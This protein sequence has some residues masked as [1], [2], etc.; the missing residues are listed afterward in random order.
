MSRIGGWRFV[1]KG[2]PFFTIVAGGAFGLCFFQQVR[3]DF[4]R[5][6]RIDANLEV[7][8]NDLSG[9]G[10]PVKKN[11]TIESVLKEVEESDTDNWENVRGPREFEDN[12]EFLQ[13]NVHRVG[14]SGDS[15][16]VPPPPPSAPNT[17]TVA[18]LG[19]DRTPTLASAS[20]TG[21]QLTFS[22]TTGS[23]GTH[24]IADPSINY[25]H[26]VSV[27]SRS[28]A[29]ISESNN[30]QAPVSDPSTSS[31]S[32]TTIFASVSSNFADPSLPDF[33]DT[34][35][36]PANPSSHSLASN[37]TDPV[38]AESVGVVASGSN[39]SHPADPEIKEED[40][41]DPVLLAQI[42]ELGFEEPIAILALAKTK[43]K[44]LSIGGTEAAVNWILEHSNE[45]DFESENEEDYAMGGAQSSLPLAQPHK[46]VFVANMSL[47]MGAGKL[48]AQ[49]GHATL[50][51][52]RLALR[53]EEGQRALDAWRLMGEMK[54]VVK[55]ESTEQLLDMFKQAKDA[56]LFAY[57]VSDAGR[58]QIPAGS[59]TVLGIFGASQVVD[60][61]TGQLKLL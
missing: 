2:L 18:V 45:S 35:S 38:P 23:A 44:C 13:A 9:L 60:T 51:V 33:V 55:G 8:K 54:V 40:L 10:V 30:S 15:S 29:E 46:M 37:P 31:N 58:T 39:T 26:P 53:S 19:S 59:R 34:V 25:D 28:I 32:S 41:V 52:Y 61:I 14:S 42:L 43:G 20:H 24:S 6:Q 4:R 47:K 49:V 11:V 17:S 22:S 36:L 7:L 56:G 21:H 1:R 50:G 3:Y 48:A 57:V 27:S 5:S 12:S 16:D